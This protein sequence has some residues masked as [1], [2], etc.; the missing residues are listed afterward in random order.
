MVRD[1]IVHVYIEGFEKSVFLAQHLPELVG[2]NAE[3]G[4][5]S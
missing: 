5:V 3:G 4:L 2:D 1:P